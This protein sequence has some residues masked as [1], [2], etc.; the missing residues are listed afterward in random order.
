MKLPL[1]G[2]LWRHPDFIK[3]WSGETVSQFGTQVTQLALPTVAILLLHAGPFEVGL[4]AALEFLAFPILGLVAGVWA[5]RLRRRPI[6]IVADL[7]RMLALGSI[8]LAFILNALSLYQLYAVAV[9]TGVFTVFF[10]VAYQS[11]LPAL[12]ERSNLIEGN[13]KLEVTR[14]AAQVAGPAV[15][16]FLIQLVGGARAILVDA[17]SFLI[18]ALALMAIRKPEP[19]PKPSMAEGK[20]GFFQEMGEGLSV[21]LAIPSCA[22]SPPVPRRPIWGA[23]CC[24]R[25]T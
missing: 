7:G 8:P 23:T 24:S 25:S 15:A 19:E 13:T 18:S 2:R 3:L 6:M 21:V 5:D 22:A 10:D 12:V 16:G 17:I 20:A 11:Y 1:K 9:I 4:L 14:S